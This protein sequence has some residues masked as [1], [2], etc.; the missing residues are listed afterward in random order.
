MDCLVF[1]V[2]VNDLL[3]FLIDF[4][5]SYSWSNPQVGLGPAVLETGLG[6]LL[7]AA[8]QRA[9]NPPPAREI[10]I[11]DEV[12]RNYVK[13]RILRSQCESFIPLPDLAEALDAYRSRLVAIVEACREKGVRPVFVTHPVLWHENMPPRERALLWM[14]EVTGGGYTAAEEL[15]LGVDLFNE[16]LL[17]TCGELSVECLDARSMSGNL[18]YFY[19]DC[20]LNEAGATRLSERLAEYFLNTE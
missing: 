18:S 15:R 10:E 8:L 16:T 13:R 14:G 4:D 9:I 7:L 19:D 17:R 11:E 12:G 20:H 1:L 5:F 3:F 2:G 6:K